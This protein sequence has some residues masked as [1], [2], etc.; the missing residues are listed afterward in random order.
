MRVNCRSSAAR[1]GARSSTSWSAWRSVRSDATYAISESAWAMHLLGLQRARPDARFV[2]LSEALPML[3]AVKDPSE[4]ERMAAAGAAA[5]AAFEEILAVRFAG[6]RE[7]D[8]AS[9]LASLLL[10][11]GHSQVDFTIVASGPNGANPHHSPG[12]RTILAGEVVVL[13]FGGLLAGYGSD[14]TRTVSVG[15]PGEDVVAVHDVVRRA[16]QAAF[17]AVR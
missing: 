3:R 10:R 15:P 16:Q 7:V 4:L 1:P 9:D 14:T 5:D 11:H 13:D 6:R 12:D 2:S 17:E 8:V